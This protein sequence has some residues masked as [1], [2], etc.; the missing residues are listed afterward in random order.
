M[1]CCPADCATRNDWEKELQAEIE[2]FQSGP[3]EEASDM[4]KVLGHPMRL[5]ILM[6]LLNRDHCVCEIIYVLKEKQNLISY[7]LGILKEAGLIDSY[8]RSKH[9][10]YKLN[11]DAAGFVRLLKANL[12]D[13][14]AHT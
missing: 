14:R 2:N 7:N 3:F 9:K 10:I 11:G 6:M 8:Y 4:L 12:I 1:R 5:Q 13:R